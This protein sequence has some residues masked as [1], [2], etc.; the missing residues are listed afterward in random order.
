M[1]DKAPGLWMSF[2]AWFRS[3]PD[4]S[5][6]AATGMMALLRSCQQGKS[7]LSMLLDSCICAFLAF[8]LRDALGLCGV[9][10]DWAMIIGVVM[11]YLGTEFIRTLV[12]RWA[13]RRAGISR[14]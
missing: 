4:I 1:P 13:E 7:F 12:I 10:Q 6:A 11:G 9:D 3:E 14:N 5:V 8:Y 2:I